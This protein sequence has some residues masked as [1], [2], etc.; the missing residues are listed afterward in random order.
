MS[1]GADG[2]DCSHTSSP[3]GGLAHTPALSLSQALVPD[4]STP[5]GQ[6]L[7]DSTLHSLQRHFAS[8]QALD[9]PLCLEGIRSVN[10]PPLLVD[11]AADDDSFTLHSQPAYERMLS[12]PALPDSPGSLGWTPP[13]GS[14]GT[15]EPSD[16][17][18]PQQGTRQGDRSPGPS[19]GGGSLPWASARVPR[20]E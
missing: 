4:T 15:K 18:F 19:G 16:F 13:P 8:Q 7:P 20:G 9:S 10:D 17:A 12:Q 6:P 14:L 3:A 5:H 11:D 1:D 2:S